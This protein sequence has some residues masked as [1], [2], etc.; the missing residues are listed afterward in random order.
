[1]CSLHEAVPYN[2][3]HLSWG[4]Q[5]AKSL[6]MCSNGLQSSLRWQSASCS[7]QKHAFEKVLKVNISE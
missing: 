1:M 7:F 2:L 5:Q 3:I 4:T 6:Y